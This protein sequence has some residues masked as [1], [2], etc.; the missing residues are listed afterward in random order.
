MIDLIIQEAKCQELLILL[1]SHCLSDKRIA[2]LWY[3][4]N[5]TEADWINTWTMLADRYKNQ[6][7][8]IGADLKNEPHGK[9]SWGTGDLAIDWRL[10]AE[11]AGNAILEFQNYESG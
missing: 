11:R 2:E 3:E 7:N 9:A 10:A 6:T 8:V 1:D 4:D 5:F